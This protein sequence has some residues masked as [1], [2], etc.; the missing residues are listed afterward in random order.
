MPDYHQIVDQI[1][2]FV[3]ATDQTRTPVLDELAKAYAE[4]CA[5]VSQRLVRC[6][7]LLQQGLR[8]EAIQLAEAQPRL[9]DAVASLDFP[10]RAAWDEL[11]QM[12][13]L[14]EAARFQVEVAAFLN[15]AY[16]EEDP[17]QDLLRA[18]RRLALAR[19]SVK[20][21]IGV[22][23]KLAT[24]DP[25]NPV[26]TEDL[27]IFE[28]TRFRQIQLEAAEAAKRHDVGALGHLLRELEEQK[29][30]EP[31]PQ[32]LVQGLRK[33]D[34]QFRG[35]QNLAIL[36]DLEGELNDA[37]TSSNTIRGRLA[38][39]RWFT[40][41][42]SLQLSPKDPIHARVE[43]ALLWL[44]EQDRQE[45]AERQH[46]VATQS[47]L[48]ALDDP[49]RIRLAALEGM[50]N[51]VMGHGLGMSESLQRRYLERLW[52][53]HAA[54]AR[55]K[56]R[57]IA[58]SLSAAI[59]VASLIFVAIHRQTRQNDA[60]QAATV[61]SDMLEISELEQASE[62]LKKLAAADPGLLE[63]PQMREVQSRFQAASDKEVERA[64]KFDQAIR[65]AD[66]APV[67]DPKPAA[68]EI[69]R[70]LARLATEK[71]A[72][73]QLAE[74]RR[75]A[76][77]QN[78]DQIDKEMAPQLEALGTKI[79][80]MKSMLETAKPGS[81]EAASLTDLAARVQIELAS[82]GPK[83]AQSGDS[84]QALSR[85]LAQDL[86]SIRTEITQ[87]E[88]R[89]NLEDRITRSVEYSAVGETN[90]LDPFADLLE[91]YVKAF[92]DTPRA[93]AFGQLRR[94]RPVWQSILK[95]NRLAAGWRAQKDTPSPKEL[96][97]RLERTTSFLA[98]NPWYPAADRVANYKKHLEAMSRRDDK[99]DSPKRRLVQLFSD[100]LVQSIWMMRVKDPNGT[101]K[102]YYMNQP[103]S[104]RANLIRYLG[105]FD[106][107]ERARAIIMP[108]VVYSDWSPQT[109]IA[110]KYKIV[111]GQGSTLADWDRV[112]IELMTAI[113]SS[114]DMDPLLQVALLKKVADNAIEGSEPLRA[115]LGPI[116]GLLEQGDV[117]VNVPWMD[118]DNAD[119]VR[120]RPRALE[121]VKSLP[122]LAEVLKDAHR[123]HEQLEHVVKQFPRSVGWL[124]KEDNGW[125]VRCGAVIPNEAELW[126]AVPESNSL[127]SWKQVGTISGGAIKIFTESGDVVAEGRPVF[128][129]LRSI[130]KS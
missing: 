60:E 119:A 77:I 51:A 128:A 5:E 6:Q 40:M 74:R 85:A 13:G 23:R 106:G 44:E 110:N 125:Q 109:K 67:H 101:S 56:N 107:R 42:R 75:N 129:M 87:R 97:D 127:S 90:D 78:R 126:V 48:Q 35:Q 84:V 120:L 46:E 93:R 121:L 3:Q 29:W 80:Q 72:V 30:Q 25:N 8:S 96:H 22:M 47:L 116:K 18:H 38:R 7:R 36:A 61:V 19:G 27:R 95:W 111:L 11:V 114:E 130:P 94:E 82:L 64:L 37:F 33:V 104:E 124:A 52:E 41:V 92:P 15:E 31:P 66:Q 20:A 68:L 69:A 62:F 1:R 54:S 81:K 63:Y 9:L 99:A 76:L 59:L 91:Q 16:A 83:L 123:H 102:C 39:D 14:P 73:E 122:D 118:P 28:K 21:R 112:M 71:S 10:E 24:L 34:A 57:I 26:W 65:Q 117:D 32:V 113:R 115:A 108:F 53:E 70:S 49:K 50:G 17:L 2:A 58:G 100:I 105:G 98:G 86:D 88:R 45:E 103:P 89:I 43:A 79:A 12:Y 55:L 4:A